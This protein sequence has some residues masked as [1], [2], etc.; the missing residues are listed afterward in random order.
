MIAYFNEYIIVLIAL[1]LCAIMTLIRIIK[2]PTAPDR[3]VGLDTLNILRA[4]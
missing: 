1:I 2:G 4:L 3:V